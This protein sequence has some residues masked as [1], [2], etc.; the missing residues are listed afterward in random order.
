M[1]RRE[2]VRDL[3]VEYGALIDADRL[4]DWVE[5]FASDCRYSVISAENLAQD[6]PQ[7][8][9]ACDSKDMLRDRVTAYREV[10]EYNFHSDRHVIGGVRFRDESTG[11]PWRIEANYSLFQ[12]DLEGVTRLF[13]V[14]Q[15]DMSVVFEDE[16][17]RFADVRVVVDTASIPTLLATPI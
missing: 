7:T 6:L 11:G 17:P 9:M 4:E 2:A 14:G 3:V 10:N 1:S 8:L 16:R 15:Y 5:L 12:T 13:L